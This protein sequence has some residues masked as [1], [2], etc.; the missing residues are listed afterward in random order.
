MNDWALNESSLGPRC[1]RALVV[2]NATVVG[3]IA[4]AAL[5]WAQ[6]IFIPVALAIFLTFLLSPFVSAL[7]Q[8]GLRR[9]PAVLLIVVLAGLTLGG[10]GW[11]VTTQISSLLVELPAYSQNVKKKVRSLQNAAAG[12][13]RFMRML[14]DINEQLGVDPRRRVVSQD[15]ASRVEAQNQAPVAVVLEPQSPAWVSRVT[16]LLSPLLEY[17]GQLMM[18]ILLVVFML[19][20]RETLRNRIIRL[21]GNGRIV[22]TTKFVDEAGKRISRFLLMQ[23]IV[24]GCFGLAIGTGLLVIGVRYA[25]L[26][27]FLAGMLRYLPFIG[28]YLAAVFPIILGLAMFEGWVPAILVVGLFLALELVAANAVEPWLY[29]QSMGVSEIALLV[30]AAFWAFLWGPI[31][32]VLASPLTVCLVVLGRHIPELEFLS[33]LLGDEPALD[34][35]VSFYQRLLAKDQDEAEDLVLEQAGRLRVEQAYDSML[36]P[37]LV[38]TKRSRTRGDITELDERDVLQTLRQIAEDLS[39]R[40]LAEVADV[41][42]ENRRERQAGAVLPAPIP[43]VGCAA[44]DTPDRV[45][46]EMIRGLLDPLKWEMEILGPETLT[47]ELTEIVGRRQPLLVCIASIPPG[48][49]ARARYLCKRLRARF[50]DLRIVVCRWGA[51][52]GR[53]ESCRRLEEVGAEAV[54]GGVDDTLRKLASLFPILAQERDTRPDGDPR[55]VDATAH[56]KPSRQDPRRVAAGCMMAAAAP[57]RP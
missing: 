40:R 9:T 10:V 56:D 29:G 1:Q 5:Y 50:P 15:R 22:A 54:T 6:S 28:P 20:K 11:L 55:A 43:I 26:W 13:S 34:P 42:A 47:A 30:S 3:A 32:L 23:A 4:I 7:R 57:A 35:G 14:A 37:A 49:L 18:A 16:Q 33:V 45:A 8:R 27:G 36:V 24:N 25:L 44:G 52:S 21:V 46:L 38:A 31:G 17:L 48:G 12:S 39:D 19:Q 2:L 51:T 53:D 41:A